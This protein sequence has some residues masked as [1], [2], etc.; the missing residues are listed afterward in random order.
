MNY[1]KPEFLHCGTAVTAIQ[2]HGAKGGQF[3]DVPP[4]MPVG[5]PNSTPAAYESDE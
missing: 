5:A 2:G 1:A 3:I 4:T